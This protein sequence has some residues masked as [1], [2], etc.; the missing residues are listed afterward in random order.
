MGLKSDDSSVKLLFIDDAV[1]ANYSSGF[2]FTVNRPVKAAT[3]AITTDKPWESC[4]PSRL[5]QALCPFV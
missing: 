5:A 4:K 1:L 3:P 2:R